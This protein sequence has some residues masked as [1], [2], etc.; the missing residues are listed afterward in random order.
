MSKPARSSACAV[1]IISST[2]SMV[3]CITPMRNG[4]VT[5]QYCHAVVTVRR[6]RPRSRAVPLALDRPHRV[7]PPVVRGRFDRRAQSR[8]RVRRAPGRGGARADLRR[9]GRRTPGRPRGND[10]P[11]AQGRARAPFGARGLPGGRDRPPAGGGSRRCGPEGGRGADRRPP[12]G[13]NADAIRIFHSLG[14]DVV[15]RVELT[16]DLGSGDRWR[17]GEE[18]AGRT[19]RV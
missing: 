3:S 2:G 15:T 19:F 14:F 12:T 5:R 17:E 10:R 1:E 13:R 16:Y 6:Y 8:V 7:A 4:G 11:R 18:L 9:G